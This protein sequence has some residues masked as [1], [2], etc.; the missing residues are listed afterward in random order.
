MATNIYHPVDFL[1]I[2]YGV[3]GKRHETNLRRLRSKATIAIYDPLVFPEGQCPE[4]KAAIIASPLETHH[5]YL[6]QLGHSA[7]IPIY[8]EKPL[9]TIQLPLLNTRCAVGYNH[10]FHR[11]WPQIGRLAQSGRLV[12]DAGD[13]LV[14]RYGKTV[15]GTMASHAIDMALYWL[16]PAFEIDM[17]S[18]GIRLEGRIRHE[19][20]ESRYQ[21]Q[22]DYPVRVSNVG[23]DKDRYPLDAD[24]GSY[25]RYLKSWLDWLDGEPRHPLLATIEDGIAVERIIQQITGDKSHATH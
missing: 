21:Y 15:A 6:W 18:D 19:R 24:E 8:C 17:K 1:I 13:N 20:G 22:M 25:S 23:D 5:Q 14:R 3:M 16:G 10:R 9:G 11:Q 12:F 4:A 7:N 2:G